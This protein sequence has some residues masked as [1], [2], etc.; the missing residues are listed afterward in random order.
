MSSFSLFNGSSSKKPFST[1]FVVGLILFGI[2]PD[3]DEHNLLVLLFLLDVIF[4][5]SV[6]CSVQ[7]PVK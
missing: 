2:E 4:Q 7:I 6:H 1:N 5:A 3:S